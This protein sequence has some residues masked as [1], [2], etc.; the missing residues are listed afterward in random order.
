MFA[1]VGAVF[2]AHDL[3]LEVHQF[4]VASA[5]QDLEIHL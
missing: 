4:G 1:S 5:E 2:S 3:R